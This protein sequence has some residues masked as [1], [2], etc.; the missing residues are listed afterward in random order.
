MIVQHRDRGNVP[1][2][3]CNAGDFIM[4]RDGWMEI[5]QFKLVPQKHFVRLTTKTDGAVEITLSHHITVIRDEGETSVQA[6]DLNLHDFLITKTGYSR[7][8]SIEFVEDPEGEKAVLTVSEPHT[9]FAG[10]KTPTILISNAV[11]IS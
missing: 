11:P 2:G 1:V 5:L 10:E 9:F 7:L 4:G 3:S 8:K 6:T